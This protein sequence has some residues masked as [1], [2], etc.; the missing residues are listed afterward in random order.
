MRRCR[1]CYLHGIHQRAA[2]I[3]VYDYRGMVI[4]VV[5]GDTVDLDIDLGLRVFTRARIRLAGI[6]APELHAAQ[7]QAAAEYLRGL[8][9]FGSSVTLHTDKD[10]TEKYGR[11][12]A[13]IQTADGVNVSR[14]MIG[15]GNAV[16][17]S[18]GPRPQP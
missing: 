18:G 16:P 13:D 15:S 5:D 12:L 3:T 9:P 4:R 10:H 2:T 7:G 14:A 1:H 17:Y 6:N 8:L 11:W